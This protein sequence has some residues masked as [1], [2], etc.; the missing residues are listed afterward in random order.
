MQDIDKNS[1]SN[2]GCKNNLLGMIHEKTN[3]FIKND[4]LKLAKVSHY[5]HT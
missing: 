3:I 2:D 1:Y 5:I 4:T